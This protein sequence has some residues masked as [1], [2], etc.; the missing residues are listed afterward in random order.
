M[1][2]TTQR[3]PNLDLIKTVAMLFVIM[4]HTTAAN[5]TSYGIFYRSGIATVPLFF[6]VAGWLLIPKANLDW[7]Y[8][9]RKVKAIARVMAIAFV[10]VYLWRN[11]VTEGWAVAPRQVPAHL[12]KQFL[13]SFLHLDDYTVLWFFGALILMYLL[14]PWL[15]SLYRERPRAFAWVFGAA[16]A[17]LFVAFVLNNTPVQYLRGLAWPFEQNVPQTLRVW[18]W[19]FYFTLGAMLRRPGVADAL[20]P[21]C[22]LMA[23]AALLILN[24]WAQ[25]KLDLNYYGNYYLEYYY[26]SPVTVLLAVALFVWLLKVPLP[27]PCKPLQEVAPLFVPVYVFHVEVVYFFQSLTDSLHLVWVVTAVSTIAVSWALMRIPLVRRAFT[28]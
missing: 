24:E 22:T 6:M 13:L 2:P 14:T 25:V 21:H 7:A 17:L 5:M 9:W 23:V 27:L 1:T 11:I 8:V 16:A 26:S 10:I 4:V 20:K 19:F 3:N 28:I 15:G 18:N 12:V